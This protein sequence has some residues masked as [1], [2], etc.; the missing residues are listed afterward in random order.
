MD[1]YAFVIDLERNGL[2]SGGTVPRLADG[3]SREV[4]FE[5]VGPRGH[6]LVVYQEGPAAGLV[7]SVSGVKVPHAELAISAKPS[8]GAAGDIYAF[9]VPLVPGLTS[10]WLEFC[11]ELSGPR[12][13][14]LQGQ[15]DRLG[16][17][18]QV[19]I[20]RSDDADLVIP[21]IE[22]NSPWEEDHR[23]A[24]SAHPFDSWFTEQLARF[25]GFDPAAPPPPRNVSVFDISAV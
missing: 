10:E 2:R 16:L 8:S 11:A 17:A 15:R 1:T 5:Q 21:V 23:I 24:S 14:E 3:L 13:D 4:A 6:W 18:E 12:R 7:T 25:H 22:G 9:T 20:Q 19:F